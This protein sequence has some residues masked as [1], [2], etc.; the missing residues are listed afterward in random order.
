MVS[1]VILCGNI[2][3]IN[4]FMLVAQK[5]YMTDGDYVYIAINSVSP[6]F[7]LQPDSVKY[8]TNAKIMN[9]YFPLLQVKLHGKHIPLLI[10]T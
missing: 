10:L 3:F 1:V 9:A 5:H 7:I 2:A 8:F 4:S 6:D